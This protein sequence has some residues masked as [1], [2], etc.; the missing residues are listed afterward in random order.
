MA[1]PRPS[2]VMTFAAK[3]DTSVKPES[4]RTTMKAPRMARTPTSSGVARRHQAA[5][6]QHQQ[7]E[8]DRQRQHLGP[9]DVVLD[10]RVGVVQERD[11]AADLGLD[12]AP[13][14]QHR[15]DRLEVGQLGVLVAVTQLDRQVGGVPVG[16]DQGRR[17]GVVVR[18]SPSSPR[19]GARGRPGRRSTGSLS[20]GWSTVAPGAV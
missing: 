20:P 11:Q 18:W 15:S 16:R 5:E 8:Q 12:P 3:T 17:A 1:M 2:I 6:D 10:L 9:D 19:A 13:G 14:G 7:H 4:S